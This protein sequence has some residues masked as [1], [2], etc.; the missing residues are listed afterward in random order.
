MPA[1]QSRRGSEVDTTGLE[2]SG[3][4]TKFNSPYGVVT[5]KYKEWF[6]SDGYG[7]LSIKWFSKES[8]YVVTTVRDGIMRF[9]SLDLA[10]EYAKGRLLEINR[11]ERG[12][13][14]NQ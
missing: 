1:K 11:S 3:P 7:A 14:S 12:R 5:G 9:K 6:L 4:Y 2:L 13:K 10:V 8:Q